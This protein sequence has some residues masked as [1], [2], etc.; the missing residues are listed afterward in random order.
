M[1]PGT[2]K[3]LVCSKTFCKQSKKGQTCCWYAY[4]LLYWLYDWLICMTSVISV[5]CSRFQNLFMVIFWVD[6]TVDFD[7]QVFSSKSLSPS[8]YFLLFQ[9]VPEP[10]FYESFRN[11]RIGIKNRGIRKLMIEM[12]YSVGRK[13]IETGARLEEQDQKSWNWNRGRKTNP[14]NKNAP[15][16]RALQAT[17]QTHF[18][19]M[20]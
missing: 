14:E 9:Y 19:H 8:K 5:F 17:K 10:T 1:V 12:S 4:K 7:F 3:R 6:P 16:E 20:L 15:N 18:T 11:S 13:W 2:L